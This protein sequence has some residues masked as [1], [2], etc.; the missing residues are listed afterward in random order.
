MTTI[1]L[2]DTSGAGSCGLERRLLEIC[3]SEKNRIG[4][5]L[6]D[7]VGQLLTG[8]SLRGKALECRLRDKGNAGEADDVRQLTVLVDE[9]IRRIRDVV[10]GLAPPEVQ[11]QDAASALRQLCLQIETVH[12]VR[13]VFIETPEIPLITEP[14][15]V[16]H[17]YF[18]A[19]ESIHN[20]IRH[21]EADQIEI[22]LHR[23]SEAE[24]IRLSVRN[25]GNCALDDFHAPT[26]AGVCGMR[27]RAQA[28]KGN[29]FISHDAEGTVTVTC[30]F[31]PEY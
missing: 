25:N 18:I 16:K 19:A 5:D 31:N 20:A 29:L 23:Y 10:A 27:L 22:R 6:H 14:Q 4:R 21:G 3:D 28:L 26:G 12:H 15:T 17:L 7:G 1:D 11:N 30:S 2:P 8:V 24:T 9:V 13:C